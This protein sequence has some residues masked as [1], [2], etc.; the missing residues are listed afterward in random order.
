M[1][2]VQRQKEDIVTITATDFNET[3][4]GQK[5]VARKIYRTEV[6]GSTYYFLHKIED[7]TTTIYT[8]NIAD[9]DLEEAALSDYIGWD[10]PVL[11]VIMQASIENSASVF[12]G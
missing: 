4:L 6:G 7:N 3:N 2:K 11:K 12:I 9:A 1:Y 10:I 5:V 8:D